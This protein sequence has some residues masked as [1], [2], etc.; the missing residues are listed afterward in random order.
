MPPSARLLFMLW[1]M[2]LTVSQHVNQGGSDRVV[3]YDSYWMKHTAAEIIYGAGEAA[4]TATVELLP[5]PDL[6]LYLKLTPE[7]LLERKR[8]DMVAYECGMDSACT[9]D[10]FLEHQRCILA[11]LNRWS[12]RRGWHELDG[13]LPADIQI[14]NIVH[15]F[16]GAMPRQSATVSP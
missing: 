16:Q 10:S 8:G 4:A 5:Q 1:S 13:A 9:D 14:A 11:Y 12:Q 3:I 2:A 6:T 15:R 7:Q